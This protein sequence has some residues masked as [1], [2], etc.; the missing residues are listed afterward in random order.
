MREGGV[1]TVAE[2]IEK[3]KAMPQ[4]A[5]VRVETYDGPTDL[6]DVELHEAGRLHTMN[7]PKVY[8]Q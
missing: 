3:L 8:L 7:G 1:M 5:V 4:D 2:L 6:T